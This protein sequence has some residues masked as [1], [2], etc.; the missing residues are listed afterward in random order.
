[1]K[2][3]IKNIIY[4]LLKLS[5]FGGA[6]LFLVNRALSV[7]EQLSSALFSFYQFAAI[8]FFTFLALASFPMFGA[9]ILRVFGIAI[10][11]WKV[12]K[13]YFKSQ[14]AKYLPGGIWAI[15]GRGYYYHLE[16]IPMRKGSQII[17]F[18]MILFSYLTAITTYPM[19]M[20]IKPDFQFS[21]LPNFFNDTV[22]TTSIYILFCFIGLFFMRAF[23]LRIHKLGKEIWKPSV[24]AVCLLLVSNAAYWSIHGMAMCFIP[25]VS[26]VEHISLISLSAVY[27]IS[28]LAGFVFFLTPAGL[29][30]REGVMISLL[31][32]YGA[33][34]DDATLV[35]LLSRFFWIAVEGILILFSFS[36]DFFS[37]KSQRTSSIS[38]HHTE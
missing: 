34:S 32:W 6:F 20:I 24:V 14:L 3:R 27:G 21:F 37:T 1:M 30:V 38:S 7:R 36:V 12:W 29:G 13:I 11:P 19:L 26:S 23:Y 22:I 35:A 9:F 10:H 28:W 8:S 4:F 17:L 33:T 5:C 15:V 25:N 31:Q 18:E 2:M 16:D